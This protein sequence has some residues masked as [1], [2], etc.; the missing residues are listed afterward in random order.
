MF[1][2]SH[3][4]YTLHSWKLVVQSEILKKNIF[5]PNLY[6]NLAHSS[7]GGLSIHLFNKIEKN[8]NIYIYI[9]MLSF[10]F[11]KMLESGKKHVVYGLQ[12]KTM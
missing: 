2:K 12:P 10:F 11:L 5:L 6:P 7:F 3:H 1:L 4:I 9:F 8:I